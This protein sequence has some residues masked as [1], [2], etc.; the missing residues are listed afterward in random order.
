MGLLV[1]RIFFPLL[2]MGFGFFACKQE[3]SKP[4]IR[5]GGLAERKAAFAKLL[6]E[7]RKDT[8]IVELMPGLQYK[9]LKSGSTGVSPSATST[10]KV[11]YTGTL[12]DGKVFDS[13][14]ERGEPISFRVDGVIKGWQE[15]LQHMKVGD[16]WRVYI[17]SSLAYGD[18]GAGADILPGAGLIFKIELL[19]IE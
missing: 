13:S 15:V 1:Y 7:N 3:S 18:R 14:E 8:S 16:I 9:V 17:A 12:I 5:D 10:V 4:E 19:G 6:E 11:H 2:F